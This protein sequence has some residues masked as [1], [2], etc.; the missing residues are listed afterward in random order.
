MNL[1]PRP[2]RLYMNVMEHPQFYNIIKQAWI[3]RATL[4][5]KINKGKAI[6]L[7]EVNE[8]MT[9]YRQRLNLAREKLKFIQG[10]M[11]AQILDDL[12]IEQEKKLIIKVEKWSSI[13]E[14]VRQKARSAWIENGDSNIKYFHAQ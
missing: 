5:I 2:F 14:Q 12:L 11:K 4:L 7:Q 10:Q 3:N 9:S 6:M 13:E 8:Y 1:H